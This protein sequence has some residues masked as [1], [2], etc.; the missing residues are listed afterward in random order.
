MTAMERSSFDHFIGVD[1]S[2]TSIARTSALIECFGQGGKKSFD[3]RCMDFLECD[4]P[5][6]GFDAVVMGEVLEH[7]ERPDV[8]LEQIARI[9][10]KG[11]HIFVTTCINATAVDHIFLFK[12]TQQL[13]KHLAINVAYVLGEK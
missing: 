5:E 11:G 6:A 1:I 9:A 2:E 8:F 7:V 3:L 13:E 4:L 12:D 10:K